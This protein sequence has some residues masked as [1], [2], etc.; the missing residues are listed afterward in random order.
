MAS[1]LL[2]TEGLNE[3]ETRR[4]LEQKVFPVILPAIEDLLKAVQPELSPDSLTVG[5]V[6]DPE[7]AKAAASQTLKVD[8]VVWLA[9]MIYRKHHGIEWKEVE[10]FLAKI[11]SVTELNSPAPDTVSPPQQSSNISDSSAAAATSEPAQAS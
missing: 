1:T 8:P 9:Q 3:P 10:D 4:Y 2:E 6:V 7:V 5:T 11:P